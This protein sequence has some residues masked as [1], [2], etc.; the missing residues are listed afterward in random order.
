[1]LFNSIYL[2]YKTLVNSGNTHITIAT[3]WWQLLM[4]RK[5]MIDIPAY[6]QIN[7]Q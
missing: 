5:T 6:N 4:L 2:L 3:D 1:M 7:Y